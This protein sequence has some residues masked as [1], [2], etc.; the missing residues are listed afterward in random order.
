MKHCG[1]DVHTK[2]TT[3]VWMDDGTGEISRACA[4][5]N[6]ELVAYLQSLP[7]L[8]QVVMEAGSTSAF[9]KRQFDTCQIPAIVVDA[10]KASRVLEAINSQAKTDKVDAKGLAI[11]SA[12]GWAEQIAVWVADPPTQ[13]LRTLTRSRERWS[14]VSNITRNGIRATI[15]AEGL[16]CAAT[17]LTGPTARA[18]LD[19]I[20]ARLDPLTRQILQQDRRMLDQIME[21]IAVI[22]VLLKEIAADD[23]RCRQLDTIAGCGVVTAAAVVAEIGDITRFRSAKA[24]RR[25]AGLTPKIEQSGERT[26]TGKLVRHCNKHLRRA[27][28]IIAQSFVKSARVTDTRAKSCYFRCLFRH[29][30]NPAKVDLARR[31]CDIIFAMLRDRTDFDPGRLAPAKAR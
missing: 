25:Y 8:K 3:V 4:M 2:R 12:R 19:D 28:I 29:G 14:K 22:D 1:L 6:D 7:E 31:L 26:V 13:R 11:L 30:P 23:E 10:H 18:W 21:N 15:R 27:L 20:E 17:D 24:L 5:P 9:L 16:L